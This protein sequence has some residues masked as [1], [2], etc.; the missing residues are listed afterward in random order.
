MNAS[1]IVPDS[2]IARWLADDAD[3]GDFSAADFGAL[4]DAART[5]RRIDADVVRYVAVD[6]YG[7]D[8]FAV[9]PW[10]CPTCSG[11]RTVMCRRTPHLH[12]HDPND[13]GDCDAPCPTCTAEGRVRAIEAA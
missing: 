5:D 12:P 2:V 13:G 11:E 3:G 6:I 10:A 4:I 7:M 9:A 1:T 8:F